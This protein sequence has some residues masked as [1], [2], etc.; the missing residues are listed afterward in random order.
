MAAARFGPLDL[1]VCLSCAGVWF[2]CGELSQVIAA[3]PPILRRLGERVRSAAAGH[4][5]GAAVRP[6]G[7][8]SCP[9]CRVPLSSVEY[10]AMQGLRL[11]MCRFCEGFWLD[12]PT[13]IRLAAALEG[14]SQW[15]LVTQEQARVQAP[16]APGSAPASSAS[17]SS[18]AART[19]ACPRCGE[20]NVERAAVCWACGEPLQGPVVGA[21]PRC[22]AAMRRVTSEKVTLSA[23]EGCG[24]VW[25]TPGRL[26]SL[27][28]QAAESQQRLLRQLAR[29]QPEKRRRLHLEMTCP[30]CDMQMFSGPLGMLTQQQV[31]TCPK[32]FGMFVAAS[33]LEEI[34]PGPRR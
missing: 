5:L 10:A 9:G 11:D 15:E 14:A 29:R 33:I 1:D 2:D 34:L 24:G 26:N 12:H 28:L 31:Q 21:C 20:P 4:P 23:C 3:G 13:L 18:P 16:P 6:Q 19:E 32:C 22:E 7:G 25:V 27:L 17:A 8:R 30:H